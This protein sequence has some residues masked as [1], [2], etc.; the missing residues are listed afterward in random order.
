MTYGKSIAVLQSAMLARFFVT[1]RL[2]E[3]RGSVKELEAAAPVVDVN[4]PPLG[5]GAK[6]NVTVTV[7]GAGELVAGAAV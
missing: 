4:A 1:S 6:L 2:S 5:V 7:P 3:N